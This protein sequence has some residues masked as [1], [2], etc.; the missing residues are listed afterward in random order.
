MSRAFSLAS[1]A[2][3][4]TE[5]VRVSPPTTTRTGFCSPQRRHSSAISARHSVRVDSMISSTSVAASMARRVWASTGSPSSGSSSLLPPPMRRDSP[6]AGT[7][8]V[9]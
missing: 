4:S 2:A 6:A 5:W 1:S 9:Q 8:M 7:I 3:A